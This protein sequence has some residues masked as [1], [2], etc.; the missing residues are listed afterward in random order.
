MYW[1]YNRI[2]PAGGVNTVSGTTPTSFVAGG[3]VDLKRII[4]VVTTAVTVA[5]A[6]VTVALNGDAI[7][8]I[9]VPFSDSAIGDAFETANFV[10]IPAVVNPAVDGS[11]V[12]GPTSGVL[13]LNP[14]DILSFTSDG[15]ATAGAV[16]FFVEYQALG[17][18]GEDR[19]GDVATIQMALA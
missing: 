12:N 3:P 9:T 10:G 8:T 18:S 11:S 14:G 1:D 16:Q 17:F 19:I 6:V 15:G 4:G 7:G 13:R 5:D 2:D